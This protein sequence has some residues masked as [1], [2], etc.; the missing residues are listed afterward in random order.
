MLGRSGD[1]KTFLAQLIDR[2]VR[3]KGGWYRFQAPAGEVIRFHRVM[4]VNWRTA[5]AEMRCGDF[6]RIEELCLDPKKNQEN[7]DNAV[8]FAV[9]DDLGAADE[10][11]KAYLLGA[12]DRV[13]DCRLGQWTVFT[14]N[15]TLDQIGARL[16]PRIASR[17]LRGGNRVVELDTEDYNL[18]KR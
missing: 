6:S 13:A 1:G 17:M 4:W 8:W 18:R 10:A 11:E 5:C 12:L 9:I 15:L 7:K 16:D 14:S 2:F 3:D